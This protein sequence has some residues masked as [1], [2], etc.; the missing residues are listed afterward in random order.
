MTFDCWTKYCVSVF[1][2][3]SYMNV[4]LPIV[5]CCG[6]TRALF[7][8]QHIITTVVSNHSYCVSVFPLVSYMNMHLPIVHCCGTIIPTYYHNSGVK[9][10]NATSIPRFVHVGIQLCELHKPACCLGMYG[11]KL[12]FVVFQKVKCLQ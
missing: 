9:S 4:H 1:P 6:T 12:F 8:N 2:L 11:Q 5:L 7:T 10:L 3:V